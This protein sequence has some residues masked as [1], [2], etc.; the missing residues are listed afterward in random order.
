MSKPKKQRNRLDELLEDLKGKLTDD[1]LEHY[2]HGALLAYRDHGERQVLTVRGNYPWVR[3]R[4]FKVAD[5]STDELMDW[6]EGKIRAHNG[7]QDSDVWIEIYHRWKIPGGWT[8]DAARDFILNRKEPVTTPQGYVVDDRYRNELPLS[9]LSYGELAGMY[10]GL[11]NHTHPEDAVRKQLCKVANVRNDKDLQFIMKQYKEGKIY[12]TTP[13]EQLIA[14]LDARKALFRKYGA[15]VD[16]TMIA[17]NQKIVYTW[18]RKLTKLDYV[19][20]ADGWNGLL[21][22][23]DNNYSL[24]FEATK[25]RRGWAQLELS[26]GNLATFDRLLTLIV[27]TRNPKTRRQDSRI[28]QMDYILEFV[29]DAQERE[30]LNTFYTE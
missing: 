28:Y 7:T 8:L 25:V 14:T 20:F 22:Y 27:G 4:N 1:E 18:L 11:L 10:L 13:I 15:R 24:L 9:N 2:S 5:W 29:L 16:D 3:T 26:P 6:I 30:N 21:K 17:D 23:V 19:S 12:M